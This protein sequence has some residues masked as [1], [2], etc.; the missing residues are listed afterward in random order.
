[1]ANYE[2][3]S[4]QGDEVAHGTVHGLEAEVVH[5]LADGRPGHA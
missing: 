5:N 3:L 1:M 4:L 2:T